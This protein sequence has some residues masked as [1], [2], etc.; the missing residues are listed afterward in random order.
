[1]LRVRRATAADEG[2]LVEHTN[3]E[4][5]ESDGVLPHDARHGVAAALACGRLGC[6]YVA[7]EENGTVVASMAVSK[8]WSDWRG[9][10]Y[11][12]LSFVFI[13]AEAR[14]R[15]IFPLM[16]AHVTQD[17]CALGHCVE[18]RLQVN[19]GNARAIRAYEKAG[20]ERLPYMSMR[21]SLPAAPAPVA[22]RRL[23][24]EVCCDCLESVV[25]AIAGGGHRLELC[26]ALRLGGLTPSAG[27]VRRAAQLAREARVACHVLIRPRGGN[28]VFSADEIGTMLDDMLDLREYAEGFVIGALTEAGRIDV[29][30]VRSLVKQSRCKCTFNRAFDQTPDLLQALEDVIATGCERVLTSGGAATAIA[31]KDAIARLVAA[32][33]ERLVVMAGAGVNAH[34]VAQLVAETGVTEVHGSFSAPG[35]IVDTALRMGPNDEPPLIASANAI[36]G[37]L[38]HL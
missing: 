11:L 18:G 17:Q 19:G 23:T 20:F 24:L 15:G 36:R 5:L 29:P 32:A 21:C 7:E 1:M 33:G 12:Y 31:G 22:K 3:Q 13:V 35:N 14:G 34:N 30:V 10:F 25:E 26:S 4:S 37:A 6:Y 9:G 27:F 16:W 2:L 28:F 8:E 38:R